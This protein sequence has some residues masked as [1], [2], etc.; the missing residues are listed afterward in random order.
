[1]R[2]IFVAAVLLAGLTGFI[3]YNLDEVPRIIEAPDRNVPGKTTGPG[4]NSLTSPDR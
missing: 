1:M 4:R 3:V 2:I